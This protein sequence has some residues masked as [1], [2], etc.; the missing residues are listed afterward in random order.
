MIFMV[1]FMQTLYIDALS[2][3]FHCDSLT[4]HNTFIPQGHQGI[5]HHLTLAIRMCT[6]VCVCMSERERAAG[7]EK[8]ACMNHRLKLQ[9]DRKGRLVTGGEELVDKD[10]D[11]NIDLC[12][13]ESL[14]SAIHTGYIN[15]AKALGVKLSAC[16]FIIP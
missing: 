9:T 12:Q 6:N 7:G 5:L 14:L 13:F 3:V 11:M 1:V 2:F 16:Q 15:T 4:Y 8:Y 10:R